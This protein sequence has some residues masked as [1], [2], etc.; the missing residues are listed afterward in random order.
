MLMKY[1]AL[2][3][4]SLMVSVMVLRGQNVLISTVN[5]PAEP[6]IAIDPKHPN[7]LIGAAG[8]RNY[9]VSLDTGK[10]WTQYKL[11]SS[12]GVWG[13]AAI[14]V[15]TLGNFYFFHLSM[16]PEGHWIDR[17][18]CQRT[19]DNGLSFND[20]SY[21]GLNGSKNQD[22]HWCVVDRRDNAIYM[23]WTQFD[24][25]GSVLGKDSS[26]IL[27][28][29]SVNLGA[30]WSAP[31]RI[32]NVAG[33]CRDSANTVEGAVP[34]VGPNGEVYVA[35]AGPSGLVFNKSINKGNTWMKEEQVICPIPGGWDFDIHGI[36]RCNGL[37]ITACDL[38]NGA[39]RGTIYV[40]WSDQ[41]NGADN[42][43]IWLTKSKDGGKTW[44]AA[45]RVN[46]DTSK[47][48]QFM[49]FM[50]IDQTT[51]YLYF[52]F[53]DRR[54][55]SGD[56][57][58]VY[59]AVSMDGGRTFINHKVSESPFVPYKETFFGDYTGITASNGIIRP[60]WTR[61]D[62]N[63]L[64]V[65]TDLTT[66]DE[67]VKDVKPNALVRNPTDNKINITY[68]LKESAKVS[69]FV[70][71]SMG[72]EVYK[73]FGQKGRGKG[74]HTDGVDI[75]KAKLGAGSY[76]LKLKADN[77]IICSRNFEVK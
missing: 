73:V 38:S 27:F 70:T 56:S 19:S 68:K 72:F 17:I 8:I 9:Y 28:S 71:D 60:I 12:Y 52:V 50:T 37:P 44:S 66:L 13:D 45:A 51:G 31:V 42:T 26:N 32:N 21:A 53:Y 40:N 34:A 36:S 77:E 65:W 69:L 18:V 57:T 15:D 24:V 22:K 16:P 29:K 39:N 67:I 4:F 11:S 3:L 58:D 76:I 20:G 62:G 48:Q 14:F 54:N 35:W 55:Y 41:R 61:L 43:D 49:T 47:R 10:N 64:S 5:S 30:T 1:N 7:M 23:S 2:L 25:Y 33:D 6:A 75:K 74:L 46:D 63:K 59:V